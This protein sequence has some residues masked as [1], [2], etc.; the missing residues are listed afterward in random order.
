MDPWVRFAALFAVLGIGSEILYFGFLLGSEALGLYLETLSWVSGL[1][2][3]AMGQKVDIIETSIWNG[4]FMI[5]IAP[6]CDAVQLQ[7][8]LAAAIVSFPASLRHKGLGLVATISCLQIVN[9]VRI[10]S[11]YFLGSHFDEEIF[12]TVHKV[13]WPILLILIAIATWVLW[14]RW[15]GEHED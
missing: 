2:L 1:I 6:E 3:N 7:A 4:H 10:V 12:H 13:V 5:D 11:L 14:A 15:V 8:L 9:Y